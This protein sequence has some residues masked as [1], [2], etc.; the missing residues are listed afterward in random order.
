MV[1]GSWDLLNLLVH[2][3]KFAK[4][5]VQTS[6]YLVGLFLGFQALNLVVN[7]PTRG[8]LPTTWCSCGVLNYKWI[9][10]YFLMRFWPLSF[11]SCNKLNLSYQ[12][13]S[14]LCCIKYLLLSPYITLNCVVC[15]SEITVSHFFC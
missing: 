3:I 8:K 13:K 5:I 6:K 14:D 2:K 9:F 12:Y 4:V 1:I 10:S 11:G 7:N 15:F